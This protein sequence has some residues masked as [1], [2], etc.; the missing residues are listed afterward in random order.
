MY[1]LALDESGTHGG[2]TSM[3]V[4]GIA[5]HEDDVAA[6]RNSLTAV[7]AKHLTPL[8]AD[9][10]AYEIHAAE[11]KRPTRARAKR[12]GQAAR[13][14]SAWL[15]FDENTRTAIL[16]DAINAIATFT[17]SNPA[18]QPALFAAV[19]DHRHGRHSKRDETAYNHVLA[20]FSDMLTTRSS[21]GGPERGIVIH[22]ERHD[23]EKGLQAQVSRDWRTASPKFAGLAEVPLF[24]DSKASRLLQAADLVCYALY[25]YYSKTPPDDAW[26][27]PLWDR[28][29]QPDTEMTGVIHLTPDFRTGLCICPPCNSRRH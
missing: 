22:D 7:L 21:T 2:A 18:H 28:A 8:S 13:P 11:L 15:K 27:A 26:I 17:A 6:L 19:V 20:K 3:L 10:F 5:V 12:P 25:R 9:A 23:H 29:Y 24:A 16:T 1:M 4:G 14:A